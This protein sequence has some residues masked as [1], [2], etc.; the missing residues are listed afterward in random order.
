M[1]RSEMI[2][3]MNEAYSEWVDIWIKSNLGEGLPH[4]QDYILNKMEE[5]GML[6]PTIKEKNC[7]ECGGH[8]V[9]KWE[10]E[11]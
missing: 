6:P 10:N 7:Y 9:N 1:K 4:M 2:T 5:A 11:K 3:I 8:T